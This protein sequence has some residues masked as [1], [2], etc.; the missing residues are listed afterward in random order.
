[1]PTP[2]AQNPGEHR[3]EFALTTYGGRYFGNDIVRRS[4][5]YAMPPKLFMAA[6][7]SISSALCQCA[8]PKIVFS[9]ARP[10]AKR[11]VVLRVYNSSPLQEV[12]RLNFGEGT[13]ART[14]DLAGRRVKRAMRRRRD[15]S[16]E[17]NFRPFEIVSLHIDR[18]PRK[19]I[20]KLRLDD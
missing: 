11:N 7:N 18:R 8:N 13:R 2:G 12:A 16:I 10:D 19:K 6:D 5:A 9:T 20:K 14:I 4:H 17:L 3:F 1:M 15:G